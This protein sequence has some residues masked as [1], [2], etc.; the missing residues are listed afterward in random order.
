M[1]RWPISAGRYLAIISCLR[2]D[3]ESFPNIL[4]ES[5]LR[6]IDPGSEFAVDEGMFGY[7]SRVDDSSPQRYIPRKPTP[8]GLLVYLACFKTEAC[9]LCLF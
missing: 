4:R 9:I 7:Y 3:W 5:W 6:R 1:D 8:N 2:C